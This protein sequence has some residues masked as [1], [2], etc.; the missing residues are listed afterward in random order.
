MGNYIIAIGGTGMRCVESFV[1]L[2][3]IGMMDNQK[4]K[5]LLLDTDFHNGNKSRVRDLIHTYIGIRNRDENATT[6]KCGPAL[7]DSFFSAELELYEFSPHYEGDKSSFNKIREQSSS[8]PKDVREENQELADLLFDRETQFFNLEHGYRAQT[9]IGSYLMYHEIIDN[10]RKVKA[11]ADKTENGLYKFIEDLT[12][13]TDARVFTMGSIFGGTGASSIPI[14]PRAFAAA[15]QE[16]GEGV[17]MRDA[18]YGSTLLTNYFT[19]SAP[20]NEQLTKEGVIASAQKFA[21]NSQAALMFYER[22]RMVKDTYQRFYLIGWPNDLTDYTVSSQGKVLTGGG[23][24]KNNSHVLEL[25]SGFSARH[26]FNESDQIDHKQHDWFFRSAEN[27]GSNFDFV[28][29]DFEGEEA[30]AFEKKV[31]AFYAMCMMVNNEADGSSEKLYKSLYQGDA[32]KTIDTHLR[33]E[34]SSKIFQLLDHYIANFAYQF[35]K[36]SSQVTAGWL[37]QIQKTA[38]QDF[39]FDASTYS[40][41]AKNLKKLPIG[42]ISKDASHHFGKKSF[43]K[44]DSSFDEFVSTF[45]KDE[46]V[47]PTEG[48]LP[49]PID[50]FMNWVYLS[51]VK[52]YKLN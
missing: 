32:K 24:Q 21:L 45:K 15:S 4:V 17:G 29:S 31:T 46:S 9:H 49:K 38:N 44:G 25:L 26:F 40:A 16:I 7:S 47:Y 34:I 50:K 33:G 35:G 27:S 11:G 10:V 36:G 6:P 3:A 5:I 37:H 22:D 51:F 20:Q 30:D 19:F 12:E 2:C 14:I 39:L 23:N 28:F 52:L 48:V 1:H 41:D 43:L 42:K 13:D 8:I 18:K